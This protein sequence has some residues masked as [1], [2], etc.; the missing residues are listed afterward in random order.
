MLILTRKL[1][2]SIVIDKKIKVK[3]LEISEGQIRLGF[4]APD[5]VKIFRSEVFDQIEK[6]NIEAAKTTKNTVVQVA[7]M[8]KGSPQKKFKQ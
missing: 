7:L 5:N 6:Q 2:E 3:I 8:L 4:E 1:N